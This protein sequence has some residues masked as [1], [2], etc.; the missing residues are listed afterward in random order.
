LLPL[1][2]V[3]RVDPDAMVAIFPADHFIVE[4]ARF[5]AYVRAAGRV[6]RSGVG[7]IVIL[8]VPATRPDGDYGWIEIDR[9]VGSPDADL[10]R[11]ARFWEKPS[12]S[13]A[14]WLHAGKHLLST[15]VTVAR[16]AAL[17]DLLREAEPALRQPFDRI[18]QALGEQNENVEITRVY[19][20]MPSISLSSG[21]FE[22]MPSRLHALVMRDVHWSDW[23]REDRINE[24]LQWLDPD[25]HVAPCACLGAAMTRYADAHIQQE[26]L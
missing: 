13:T 9:D 3:L 19:S 26:E 2:H 25:R 21:G 24:T 11:V 6:V 12:E 22:R 23:G 1:A 15:M 4:E 20:R 18:K 16:A 8:G 7:E 17:W 14:Q 10:V 5:A